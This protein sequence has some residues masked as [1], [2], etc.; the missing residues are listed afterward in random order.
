MFY[1]IVLV[2]DTVFL[3]PQLER[4]GIALVQLVFSMTCGA[5]FLR[6][7]HALLL[8]GLLLLPVEDSATLEFH[9]PFIKPKLA[10]NPFTPGTL[11][12]PIKNKKD[13][14]KKLQ[15]AGKQFSNKTPATHEVPVP[16]PPLPVPWPAWHRA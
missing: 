4:N 8:K 12:T 13:Y 7:Q 15:G 1:L 16:S 10:T 3:D 14:K 6:S 5:W 11:P 9:L 2:G